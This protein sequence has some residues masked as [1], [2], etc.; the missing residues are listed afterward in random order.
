MAQA[1]QG[2]TV[3]VHYKGQLEDGTVFDTSEGREPLQFT[4]GQGQVIPGFEE[5]ILGMEPGE[6]RAIKVPADQAYGDHRTDRV[7][8]VQR[9]DLPTDMDPAIGQRL[10]VR[11]ANGPGIPVTVTSVTEADVTLDANHPL[12]GKDLIFETELVEIA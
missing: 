9:T 1:K 12:A 3:K 11:Q 6:S 4:L 8:T 10:E 2:D 7:L 5:G